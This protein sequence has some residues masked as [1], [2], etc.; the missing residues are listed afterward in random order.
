[1]S[2]AVSEKPTRPGDDIVALDARAM[3]QAIR[4]KHLS[5]REVMAAHLNR[6]E[7][8]NPTVNAIVSLRPREDLLAE[9]DAAD[10]DLARGRWRGPL[11]GLPHAV[12]DLAATRGLRTTFGSPLFADFVPGH[13]ALFVERLRAAGAILI[14]KTNVPEFGLGS[15]TYNPV[16]GS[17]GNA[18]DPALTSGGSSGGAAVALALGM[19][20]LADGSDFA[21]SLRN[22]AG[23]NG[24]FG[25]RPS[26]GRVPSLPEPE[27]YLQQLST[28]GPMARTVA[29]LSLL[30][31]VMSG[32]DSRAPL[33]RPE[34]PL[35]AALLD[36][37]V[38]G[39]RIGWL[40][41]LDG[42]L[43]MEDGILP[44]CERALGALAAAGCAVEPARLG[45][46]AADIWAC[47]LT[48][49]HALV[50]GK[51]GGLYADAAK[52]ALLKPELIWEIEGGLRLTAGDLYI[53]A[54][55]RTRLYQAF[56]A[57]F[58]R[59]DALALPSAQCFPFARDVAWPTAIA[60]RP[61]DSYHRWMEV[62]V[63]GTLS[64]CPV[65][66]LPAGAGGASDRPSGLQ[67]IGRP[68]ADRELLRLASAFEAE[69]RPLRRLPDR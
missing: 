49:R 57:L 22:P 14:G 11:H 37:D 15:Q 30:L 54:A 63:P 53:A 19:V 34:P 50:A 1:M 62:V 58:E 55:A 35:C 8:V 20:P 17:T 67:L 39:R 27:G 60:G 40:G 4:S 9:A 66:G 6:I 10:H 31:S 51:F 41:D 56:T 36:G 26:A 33:A 5:C 3:V 23:W 28:D 64:G 13:D 2:S 24:V 44:L 25:F 29:D 43:A 69:R 32:A 59:F 7:A 52:R 68:G 42:A 12:K 61:M 65:V 38:A 18:Y 46:P 16:F 21:G 48:W 47:W 45:M